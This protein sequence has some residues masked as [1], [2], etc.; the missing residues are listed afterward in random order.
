MGLSGAA[1]LAMSAVAPAIAE[2]L[3]ARYGFGSAFVLAGFA[4]VLGAMASRGLPP[5]DQNGPRERNGWRLR[6]QRL[7]PSWPRWP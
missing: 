5:R 3:G 2:P 4:A 1:S 6:A 7:D